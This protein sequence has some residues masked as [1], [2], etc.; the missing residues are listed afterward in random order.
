VALARDKAHVVTGWSNKVMC[1]LA[2]FLPWG[3]VTRLSG[4]VL[5][6]LRGRDRP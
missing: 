3:L 4:R 1:K 5:T 6:H 2:T